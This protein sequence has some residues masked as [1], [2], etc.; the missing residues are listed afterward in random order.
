VEYFS[1]SIFVVTSEP[2]PAALPDTGVEDPFVAAGAAMGLVGLGVA[3]LL[4]A[5][6]RRP[7]KAR[8]V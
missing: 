5:V 4:L 7:G 2:E 3:F 1:E 8:S 6:R